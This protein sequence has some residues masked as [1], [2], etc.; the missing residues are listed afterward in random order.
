MSETSPQPSPDLT[1][2]LSQGEGERERGR[3]MMFETSPHDDFGSEP[4]IYRLTQ[5]SPKE[6]ETDA[7]RCLSFVSG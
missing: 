1:P 4:D 2:T 5:P 6:R 7:V 3:Q